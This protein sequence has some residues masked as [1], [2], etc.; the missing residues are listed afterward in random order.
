MVAVNA[1]PNATSLTARKLQR[2]RKNRSL[3]G[4]DYFA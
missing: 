1:M 4:E 2:N 3:G